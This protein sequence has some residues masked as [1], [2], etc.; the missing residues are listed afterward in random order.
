MEAL[1]NNGGWMR[2]TDDEWGLMMISDDEWLI[3]GV[4]LMDFHGRLI[5]VWHCWIIIGS[6]R[7]SWRI[8]RLL[9][10]MV[11]PRYGRHENASGYAYDG[12]ANDGYA[13]D[14]CAI[15]TRNVRWNPHRKKKLYR[16]SAARRYANDGHANDE[17][18]ANDARLD[19][20][21]YYAAEDIVFTHFSF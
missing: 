17:H 9:A 11:V 14:G 1:E 5:I 20:I 7:E 19:T 6:P 3:S 15:P 21:Q 4:S 2:I 18:A 13:N 8:L 12:L 10:T 16:S